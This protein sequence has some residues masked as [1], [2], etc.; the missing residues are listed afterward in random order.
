MSKNEFEFEKFGKSNAILPYIIAGLAIL[1]VVFLLRHCNSPKEYWNAGISD[2]NYQTPIFPDNPNML[3]P[4]DTT[5]III[6]DD[7]LQRPIISN[8]LNVYLQDTTNLKSFADKVINTYSNDSILVTYFAEAYKRIQFQIPTDRRDTLKTRIKNDFKEAKFVCFESILKNFKTKTDP[9]FN[10]PNLHWFYKQIGLYDAWNTTKG[11]SSVTIAVIDNSFDVNHK[12]LVN[13]ITDPW[14]VFEYSKDVKTYG[15]LI[16]GTHVAGTAVGEIDNGFGISGV[17]PQ[18]KLMPIQ[19]A[20]R[21]GRMSTSSILDGI[22][23]ALKNKANVINLS[24]GVDLSHLVGNLN[25]QEQEAVA[26]SIYLDEAAMWNEVYEIAQKENVVIVQAAGNSSVV[27]GLDPMKRS[28]LIIVVGATSRQQ[29]IASFSN[30]GDKVDVFAPGVEIYSSIP[31]QQF[32]TMQ[33]TSMASPIISGCV[34]LIKS[35]DSTASPLKIKQLMMETGMKIEGDYRFIQI[36][37]L[38]KKLNSL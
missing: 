26:G 1:T 30:Y 10:D 17:A 16:H 4:I 2:D 22:F 8:L 20:D 28:H 38:L 19:V 34:G 11:D 7:P 13:R 36:D 25:E 33:G 23:Y 14:N 24:L 6:P 35:I 15:K 5:K 32:K 31:N 12:E 18:C 29:K 27:A 3:P 37:A 9:G 21:N